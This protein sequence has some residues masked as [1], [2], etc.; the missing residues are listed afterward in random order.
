MSRV[1][2]NRQANRPAETLRAL[3]ARV[4][5]LARG[6]LWRVAPAFAGRRAARLQALARLSSVEERLEHVGE[7]H[8]EQLERLED[9][10]R[11]LILTAEALRRS[12]ADVAALAA[13]TRDEMARVRGE[14][15]ALPYVADSPFEQM[16]APVGEV[17]GYRSAE[18]LPHGESGYVGFEDIFRGPAGRVSEL[19]RPY[20]TL[21]RGH[22]PVLD[23]GCGRGEFL[24]LCREDGIAASGVDE[25]AGMVER[26]RRLGLQVTLGDANEYLQGLPD[27]SLGAVFSAQLIEHLSHAQLRRLMELAC[28]KLRPGGVFIAE[29]VNPHRVSSLKTFW[30][31]L[32]HHHPIFPEAAL[33]LS[34]TAGFESAYVFA[35]TFESFESARFEAP[36]FAL[37]ATVAAAREEAC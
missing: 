24:A 15:N 23:V 35:P 12:V 25:D 4:R 18:S 13:L 27:A 14:L 7:R 37:V 1:D 34:S 8:G 5:P 17:L 3:S 30:V 2:E 16:R 20:L 9:L 33:A 28:S 6:V 31:D 29:T 10:A 32:T 11:E 22:E 21:V 26:C 19:Q 36:A